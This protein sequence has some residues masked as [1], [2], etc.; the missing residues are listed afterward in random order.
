MESQHT[1]KPRNKISKSVGRS[2]YTQHT[3]V[4]EVNDRLVTPVESTATATVIVPSVVLAA[5]PPLPRTRNRISRSSSSVLISDSNTAVA[6]DYLGSCDQICPLWPDSKKGP[7]FMQM[8]VYDTEHELSFLE[9]HEIYVLHVLCLIL[10]FMYTTEKK[11]RSYNGPSAGTLGA[12][13][14]G[15]TD[16]SGDFDI[17]VHNKTGHAQRISIL[18]PSYMALQYPFLFPFAEQGWSPEMRLSVSSAG[19]DRNRVIIPTLNLESPIRKPTD[20]NAEQHF[21]FDLVTSSV[22]SKKQGDGI[23]AIAAA[24]YKQAYDAPLELLNCYRIVTFACE[25]PIIYLKTVDHP[26]SLR[27]GSTVTITAIP[28]SVIYPRLYFNFTKYEDLTESTEECDVYTDFIGLVDHIVD[29]TTK[30]GD[31]YVRLFLKTERNTITATLWKEIVTSPDRFHRA[32]LDST[33]RPCTISL[34]AVKVTK[35]RGWFQLTSNP[36]TY[37]YINPIC[38]ESASLL[39]SN[40]S[41]SQSSMAY[42]PSSSQAIPKKDFSELLLL[43]RQQSARQMFMC[44]A[45]I[46]DFASELPWFKRN[47]LVLSGT[48]HMEPS[49]T[50]IF[51]TAE[52]K[53]LKIPDEFA[54]VRYNNQQAAA[55]V[56]LIF[57]TNMFWDIKIKRIDGDVYMMNGWS[58][59]VRDIPLRENHYLEFTYASDTIVRLNVYSEDGSNILS[60]PAAVKSESE[61]NNSTEEAKDP[62]SFDKR[63]PTELADL[64]SF[65][66]GMKIRV[67]YEHAEAK[68]MK[69]R[70]QSNMVTYT[71]FTIRHWERFAD[72]Y[73]IVVGQKVRLTYDFQTKTLFVHKEN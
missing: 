22:L 11:Q 44:D 38:P 71:R 8:Y 55:S 36:T 7:R 3:N 13:L 42:H 39:Q 61:S 73:A 40:Q 57:T 15:E 59:V 12:I 14:C 62:P 65:H 28:D 37:T 60:V 19:I 17:V 46:V 35:H 20:M 49:F 45:R 29:A 64:A 2:Y 50:R 24:S 27:F 70:S 51:S 72:R 66:D 23:H 58:D 31:P 48:E 6:P 4:L 67:A 52:S 41:A 69:L 9:Q 18:H 34:T 16:V 30:D 63:L 26:V 32:E 53:R 56:S 10:P 54:K 5:A 33:T 21:I 43:S 68:T 25:D 47:C 1:L